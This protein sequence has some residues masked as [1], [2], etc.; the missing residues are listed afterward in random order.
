MI[1]F[2]QHL[3]WELWA[4][5]HNVE[6]RLLQYDVQVDDS[7]KY[8]FSNFIKEYMSVFDNYLRQGRP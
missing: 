3:I 8:N 1:V 4:K 7:I 2:G 5:F 6:E